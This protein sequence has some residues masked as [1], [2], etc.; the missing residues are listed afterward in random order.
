MGVYTDITEYS[1]PIS[2]V[3]LFKALA[4]DSH[5]LVP[6]LLPHAVKNMEYIQGNGEHGSIRQINFAEG[7]TMKNRIDEANEETFTYKYTLLEGD[8]LKD[9]FESITHEV[10]FEGTTDGGS[11]NKMTITYQTKGDFQLNEEDIKEGK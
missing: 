10:K 1:S 6:K 7:K 8:A 11:K 5:N 4:I 3:R 2:P 9:K